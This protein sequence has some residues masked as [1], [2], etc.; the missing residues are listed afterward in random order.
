MAKST[1]QS[2]NGANLGFEA[3]LWQV[4]GTYYVSRG[5]TRHSALRCPSTGWTSDNYSKLDITN[6]DLNLRSQFA[7]SRWYSILHQ[8]D[9]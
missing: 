9:I 6:C 5:T 8:H 4:A 2:N 7:T 1:K 3:K